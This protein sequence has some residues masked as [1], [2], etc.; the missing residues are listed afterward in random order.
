M[1][2]GFLSITLLVGVAGFF[3]L[4]ASK[5]I[6]RYFEGGEEQFRSIVVE[7]TEVSGHVKRAETH[8]ML[9]LILNDEV[10]REK[11]FKNYESLYED[12]QT[13]DGM[14]KLPKA[15]RILDEIKSRADDLS[16]LGI[17]LIEAQDRDMAATGSFEVGKHRELMKKFYV[18]SSTIRKLGTKLAKLNMDL[19]L[20]K[21]VRAI[22]Y[23]A[24][25]QRNVLAVLV[26]SVIMSMLLGFFISRAIANPV[27]KLKNAAEELGKGKLDTRVEIKSG[28]EI[29]LLADSFNRMTE[30]LRKTTVSR[31]YVDNIIKSMID[32][33]VVVTPE[34]TIQAVNRATLTLLGYDEKELIDKPIGIIV[35]EESGTWIDDLLKQGL[36]SNVEK[37]YL[38][39]DGRKIPVLF[40]GL[41]MRDVDGRI[42]GVVCVALDI[43]ERKR[44]EEELKKAATTEKVTKLLNRFSFEKD[45]NNLKNPVLLLI[46]IDGFMRINNFYGI[47]AGDFVLKELAE[48][49]KN[50]IPEDLDANVYKLGG[51]DFGLLYEYTQGYKPGDIAKGIV[52]EIER[53]DFVYQG[54]NISINISIGISRERPLLEKA[55]MVLKY[56]KRSSRLKYLEYGEEL[57]VYRNISEN[58]R[59]HRV[60]K[61]AI[62]SD[63]VVP[64]F[65]PI[66]NNNTGRIEEYECLVRIIDEERKVLSPDSFLQVA[67]E[68]KL[69]GEI[70]KMMIEKSFAVFK[71]KDYEFSVN[72]SIED[73]NDDEINEFI[74]TILDSHQEIAR[75]A[76][77]EIIESEG[78]E[79]YEVVYNFTRKIKKYGCKIAIDD[80]GSGYSNFGYILRLDVDFIKI[81]ASLIKDVDKNKNSQIIVET[82]VNYARRVGIKTVA[83]YVHSKEVYEKVKE[84]GVDCSQGYYLGE[85]KP[86]IE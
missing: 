10:D 29:G 37:I 45:E 13:L 3:G 18:A 70:T 75:R 65:Q 83:E 61:R 53:D 78:I 9:F 31:D 41:V 47:Q 20:E 66:V 42:Q 4:A 21:K 33:L 52:D 73:V 19:E 71:D 56:L 12:I 76:I 69:Y 84:L 25:I 32:T 80:F 22:R 58:L 38:T 51:D 27:V 14:A 86:S 39:K 54:Y 36:I 74:T 26:V 1:I 48:R 46:N 35:E 34:G 8:L 43:T 72:L 15:R 55:D 57:G 77:F 24:H 85:P 40:S 64:Y 2:L 11:F 60:L 6:V 82:I 62:A 44:A 28:D 5:Q 79:N 16:S 68:S 30:D 7:A 63:A 81:D 23:A 59:M 67:K 17:S 50:I 49:L